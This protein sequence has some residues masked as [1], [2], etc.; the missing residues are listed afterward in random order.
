[1]TV[2][3]QRHRMLS[4][5]L[6]HWRSHGTA[7]TVRTLVER[8]RP[9]LFLRETHVWYEL[10]L[11][12]AATVARPFPPGYVLLAGGPEQL[13]LLEQLPTVDAEEGARRLADRASFW[14]VL[15]DQGNAAF[16]CWIFRGTAPVLAAAGG[17]L[18]LPEQFTVLEDSVTA[19]AAR[20]HGLAP[21]AWSWV[22]AALLQEG[23]A[24]LLTK[25]ETANAAS[26]RAVAK[27]GFVPFATVRYRRV[28]IRVRV[29]V[30]PHPS[31][32]VI[33]SW[34]AAALPGRLCV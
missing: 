29:L 26:R 7:Q 8:M 31:G 30:E 15:D 27:A 25:V 22:A 32:S 9:H 6:R 34:L 4:R 11:D 18:T 2:N 20:G 5:L 19:A 13:P 24:S 3:A 1:M 21:A 14:L 10:R 23:H 12:P 17:R 28:I 33:G 16:S